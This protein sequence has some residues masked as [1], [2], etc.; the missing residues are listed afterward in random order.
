ML[1]EA[2]KAQISAMLHIETCIGELVD[3]QKK[4]RAVNTNLLARRLWAAEYIIQSMND[5]P[6]PADY[7][8]VTAFPEDDIG[9]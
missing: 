2:K 5:G 1:S 9:G 6:K 3:A 7:A 8:E 4:N